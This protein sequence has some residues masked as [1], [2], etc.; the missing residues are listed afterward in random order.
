MTDKEL[1][2]QAPGAQLVDTLLATMKLA[3]QGPTAP[4]D[5]VARVL[6]YRSEIFKRLQRVSCGVATIICRKAYSQCGGIILPRELLMIKRD[7]AH[8]AGMWSIPGGKV[9]PGEKPWQT[10][11]R[12]VEE[13]T[14]LA[15]TVDPYRLVPY[16]NTIAGG[17]PWVTLYFIAEVHKNYPEPQ[18]M[19]PDK[20]SEMGW[21]DID[22][23]P[24]PL[25]EPL[26]ELV[27]KIKGVRD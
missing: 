18:I 12:E 26:V 10:A 27:E 25:F 1:A 5:L 17:Q 15:V 19:E 9:E 23:L 21:F 14:D 3:Q 6:A 2:A 8:G 7:G 4:E 11:E 24:S 20:C 22:D 16:N 13:E